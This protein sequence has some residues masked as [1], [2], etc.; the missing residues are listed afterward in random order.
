MFLSFKGTQTWV[1]RDNYLLPY[2]VKSS[3]DLPPSE[4]W[5]LGEPAFMGPI[6][7][8]RFIQDRK[9][10]RG[11]VFETQERAWKQRRFPDAEVICNGERTAVHRSTLCAA[12][13]VFDAFS[14]SMQEGCAAT[15][16]I[17][18]STPAAV[19]A[20][21]CYIYTGEFNCPSHG[22]P[23][24]E[25]EPATALRG[26]GRA[27]P[28]GAIF[29]TPDPPFRSVFHILGKSDGNAIRQQ[30]RFASTARHIPEI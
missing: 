4:G 15:Y 18:E 19:E 17:K 3:A 11:V 9:R 1:I 13:P 29:A 21:L 2:K 28:Q 16:E 26:A 12:S 27:A 6:P 7:A 20:M 10:S 24:M 30:M 5:Q 22:I 8:V 25:R 14:S 23:E